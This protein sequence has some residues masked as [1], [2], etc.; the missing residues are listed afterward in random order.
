M[1][2]DGKAPQHVVRFYKHLATQPGFIEVD[3]KA[4]KVQV[5]SKAKKE[6]CIL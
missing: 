2:A 4:P 1:V 3:K 5:N 6:V